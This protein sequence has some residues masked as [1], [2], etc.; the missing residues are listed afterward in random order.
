M[1]DCL[2]TE[3][4]SELDLIPTEALFSGLKNDPFKAGKKASVTICSEPEGRY[5]LAAYH[6]R[7][8]ELTFMVRDCETA[9]LISGLPAVIRQANSPEEAL[10]GLSFHN[11]LL[12]QEED[13]A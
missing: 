10:I 1:S 2:A 12:D 4:H 5:R 6:A 11:D 7:G 13:F 9:D 8:E 3:L